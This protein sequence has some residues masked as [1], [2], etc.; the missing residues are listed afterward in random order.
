[1]SSTPYD[2]GAVTN[3]QE[4]PSEDRVQLLCVYS[5]RTT[6]IER[7]NM[8][9]AQI[10]CSVVELDTDLYIYLLVHCSTALQKPQ[11]QLFGLTDRF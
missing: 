2:T 11:P 4:S 7:A 8:L 5:G 3:I 6:Y 1:M 10:T 9:R